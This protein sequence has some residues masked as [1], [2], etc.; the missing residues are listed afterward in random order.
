MPVT[1]NKKST[2]IAVLSSGGLDSCVLLYDL[3]VN[4]SVVPIYVS[5]GLAWEPEEYSALETFISALHTENIHN[6]VKLRMPVEEIY[7]QHWSITGE[8]V[9][10]AKDPDEK[11]YLP[12]RNIFLL[13][14]AGIWCATHDVKQI[15]LGSLAGN[16]FPDATPEFFNEFAKVISTATSSMIQIIT[17]YRDLTKSDLIK[18]FEHLPL[19]LSITCNAPSNGTHCGKCNKCNERQEAFI[20]ADVTDRTYYESKK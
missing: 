16:P 7:E 17:P 11:V 18:R 14:A 8:G 5:Q 10:S 2:P 4:Y 15:A 9:P 12:G 20:L 13:S 1:Q 19:H 3:S 6:V